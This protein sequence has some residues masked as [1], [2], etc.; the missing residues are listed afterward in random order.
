[1]RYHSTKIQRPK[2]FGRRQ[3]E[4]GIEYEV[5][6]K[7][8]SQVISASAGP[9]MLLPVKSI[10]CDNGGIGFRRPEYIGLALL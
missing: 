6:N 8:R 7:H 10:E 2:V 3:V 1:M 4:V 9:V 5:Q